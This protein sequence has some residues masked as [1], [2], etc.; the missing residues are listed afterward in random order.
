MYL[1][2]KSQF[3]CVYGIS[4]PV[5]GIAEGECFSVYRPGATILIF[6]GLGAA[7]FWFVFEDL[8][9]ESTLSSTPRYTSDDVDAVCLSVAHLSITP[10][11]SFG[12]IYAVRSV[13][14]KVPLE[15][16][17]APTWHTNR[18]VIVGDAAHKVSEE[19]L[20]NQITAPAK[21]LFSRPQMQLW[22]PI[23]PLSHPQS[24]LTS[25]VVFGADLLYKDYF[26]PRP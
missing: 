3:A 24:Y 18:L 5:Q 11:V 16:G 9:R 17:I 20:F 4:P 21:S 8:G 12:D 7:I 6:T 10:T 15:E 22:V 25:F 13:A 23:K 1:D 19:Q 26:R 14:M 2:I